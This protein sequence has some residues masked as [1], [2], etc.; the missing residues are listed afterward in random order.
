LTTEQFGR[1]M[2]IAV[3]RGAPERVLE[4][5][6]IFALAESEHHGVV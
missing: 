3:R 2:L 6:D 1:A 5:P 4:S